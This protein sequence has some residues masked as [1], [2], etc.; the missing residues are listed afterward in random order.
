MQGFEDENAM[1]PENEYYDQQGMTFEETTSPINDLGF[2]PYAFLSNVGGK[3]TSLKDISSQED[4]NKGKQDREVTTSRKSNI[5]NPESIKIFNNSNVDKPEISGKLERPHTVGLQDINS[6][7]LKNSNTAAIISKTS[8]RPETSKAV[9]ELP[10][11]FDSS[12]RRPMTA[13]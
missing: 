13:M 7:M 8:K 12:T 6:R 5:Q 10:D 3:Q 4:R 11:I 9:V 1:N 2:K